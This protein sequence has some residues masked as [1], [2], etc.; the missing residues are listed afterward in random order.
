MECI[1]CTQCIDACN[2]VMSRVGSEPGLIRFTSQDALAGKPPKLVRMRTLVYPLILT[3]VLGG[4]AY[5]VSTK[6]SFDA[7][8]IRGKGAP[9]SIDAAGVVTNTY[10][11]RLVNRSG[12]PQQYVFQIVEPDLTLDIVDESRLT[13]D[14]GETTRVPIGLQFRPT[15]TKGDGNEQVTLKIKDDSDNEKNVR[16]RVLGPRN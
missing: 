16:F 8:V 4:L 1:N 15:L 3:V 6:T 13:L 14:P 2:E 5:A 7:R 10:S 9:F 11:I 12:S